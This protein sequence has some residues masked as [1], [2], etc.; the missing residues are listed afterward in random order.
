MFLEY[1]QLL[2]RPVPNTKVIQLQSFVLHFVEVPK[3]NVLLRVEVKGQGEKGMHNKY[4]T[5]LCNAT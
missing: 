5:K 3:K 4:T 2:L 1:G